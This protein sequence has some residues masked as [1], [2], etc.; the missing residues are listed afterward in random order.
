MTIESTAPTQARHKPRAQKRSKTTEQQPDKE[1]LLLIDSEPAISSDGDDWYYFWYKV[2][3]QKQNANGNGKTINCKE[4]QN[5]WVKEAME[6][7]TLLQKG[8]HFHYEKIAT[9]NGPSSHRWR[10]V[11]DEDFRLEEPEPDED[12]PMTW[13]QPGNEVPVVQD[14]PPKIPPADPEVMRRMD[15]WFRVL[16]ECGV[17]PSPDRIAETAAGFCTSVEISKE[18]RGNR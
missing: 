9:P 17:D 14:E 15:T 11:L 3:G 12:L 8:L 10:Y 16:A 6:S 5:S 18:R 4:F 2:P 1:A 7:N 13:D